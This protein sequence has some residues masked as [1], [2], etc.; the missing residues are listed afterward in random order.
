[1]VCEEP[2]VRKKDQTHCFFAS[3]VFFAGNMLLP[4]CCGA[5]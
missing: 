3:L 1:M 2:E 5:P 4:S